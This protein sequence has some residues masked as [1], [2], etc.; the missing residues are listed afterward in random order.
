MANDVEMI[1]KPSFT[2]DIVNIHRHT[3]I[4]IAYCNSTSPG[5][6][7]KEDLTLEEKSKT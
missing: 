7:A 6:R 3:Q 5:L 1:I 2:L 4:A